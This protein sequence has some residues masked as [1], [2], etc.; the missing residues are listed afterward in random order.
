MQRGNGITLPYLGGNDTNRYGFYSGKRLKIE[1]FLTLAENARASEA[2]LA[3]AAVAGHEDAPPCVQR[4]IAD[5]VAAG[6]RNEAM[7]QTGI[8]LKR[9]FPETYEGPAL[10]LNGTIIGKPL[11]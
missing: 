11:A 1:E 9:G 7:Y 3:A 4:M 2:Q 5:G 10:G 8:Y 6:P